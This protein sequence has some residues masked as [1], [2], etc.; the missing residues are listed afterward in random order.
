MLKPNRVVT[1]VNILTVRKRLT[2]I[3]TLGLLAQAVGM[4]LLS[5]FPSST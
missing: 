3:F 4:L 5:A 1:T 2:V